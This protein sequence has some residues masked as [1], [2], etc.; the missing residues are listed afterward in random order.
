MLGLN[1]RCGPDVR[2]CKIPIFPGARMF[3][4]VCVEVLVATVVAW[5]GVWGITDETVQLVQSRAARYCIYAAL[6]GGA[7]EKGC[8]LS[9]SL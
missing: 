8:A 7:L 5:V 4:G 3:A 2:A 6:L 1:R 9:L